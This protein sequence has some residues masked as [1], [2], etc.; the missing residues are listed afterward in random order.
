[1]KSNIIRNIKRAFDKRNLAFKE[2]DFESLRKKAKEIKE[3]SI[4]NY[5]ELLEIFTRKMQERGVKVFIANSKEEARHLIKAILEKEKAKSIVSSKSMTSEEIDLKIYLRKWGFEFNETDLG[6]WICDLAFLRPKH[7]VAPAISFSRFDVKKL[8]EEKFN[9]KL[10]EKIEEL[11]AFAREKLEKIFLEADAGL[12]GANFVFAEEGIV[13]IFENEGNF[14]KTFYFPKT[15]I[16]LFG[17]EKFVDSIKNFP[18]FLRLLPRSATGQRLTSFVHLLTNKIGNWYIMII[19]GKRREIAENKEFKEILYC[20]RCGACMNVCPVYGASE[21][22]G[23]KGPYNGPIGILFNSLL[24][25]FYSNAFYSTL[26]ESCDQVCPVN[27][28]I[29]ELIRKLRKEKNL[30]F[31]VKMFVKAYSKL[32]SYPKVA[33]FIGNYIPLNLLLYFLK[34]K[35]LSNF[36]DKDF[37]EEP[38][39]VEERKENKCFENLWIEY[40]GKFGEKGKKFKVLYAI[41][42]TGSLILNSDDFKD[43]FSEK[44][45][46]LELKRKDLLKNFEELFNKDLNLDKNYL[47]VSGPSR[48]AD[49]EKKLIIGVHGPWETYVNLI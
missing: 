12:T 26:C 8:F 13:S 48:T 28:N 9:I 47:F 17:I 15:V 1:M 25:N 34:S 19:L 49:I 33:E 41:E 16:T 39:I 4:E 21:A 44:E 3:R 2:I 32:K 18:P 42:E 46:C 30:P 5:K 10:T 29:S 43:F 7:I 14:G 31:K 11:T 40:G 37:F 27:I 23:Y 36:F 24:Y 38:Y 6:E 22:E 20:I 35:K 45:V